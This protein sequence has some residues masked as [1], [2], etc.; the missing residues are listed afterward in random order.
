MEVSIPPGCREATELSP[1]WSPFNVRQ[2]SVCEF[3]ASAEL[4]V[5]NETNV[6]LKF[7]LH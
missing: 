6:E 1:I 4:S 3:F 7:D 5:G 2:T